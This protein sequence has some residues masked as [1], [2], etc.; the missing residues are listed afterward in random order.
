[1][2]LPTPYTL[3]LTLSSNPFVQWASINGLCLN[4]RKALIIDK[5][6]YTAQLLPLQIDNTINEIVDN[7]K[8]FGVI[9]KNSLNYSN[10]I[11]AVFGRTIAMLRSLWLAQYLLRLIFVCY[12]LKHIS[13]LLYCSDVNCFLAVTQK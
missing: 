1:M 11:N 6:N 4:L 12:S 7:A 13:S 5:I 9:F 3:I 10:H 8:N 2:Y